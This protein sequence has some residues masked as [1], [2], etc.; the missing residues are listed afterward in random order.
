MKQAIIWIPALLAVF[1]MTGCRSYRQEKQ[2]GWCDPCADKPA[3]A[4]PQPVGTHTSRWQATQTA[5]AARDDF[6]IY[7]YEWLADD[8][9]L[10]PFGKRHVQTLADRLIS[11]PE[12]IRLEP[13][14]NP[15]LDSRRREQLVS[16]LTERGV[17]GA[18]TRVVTAHPSA[19][20]LHGQEAPRIS[21]GYLSSGSGGFG[22]G[23][24][25]FGGGAAGGF[26][27]GGIGTGAGSRLGGF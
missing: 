18:E 23:Q 15:S 8:A 17:P 27:G 12:Q 11:E 26:G 5:L 24:G 20:G 16:V 25:G 1:V 3:G 2:L 21:N 22:G 13:S 10:S 19:E 9:R 14:E 7:Q 4:I 6:V